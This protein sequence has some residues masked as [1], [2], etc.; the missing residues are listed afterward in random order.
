MNIELALNQFYEE[1]GFEP[2]TGKRPA[3][4]EVFVLFV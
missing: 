3:F 1:S 2:E 4:V